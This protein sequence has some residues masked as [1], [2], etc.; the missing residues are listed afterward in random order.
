MNVT[1]IIG[2]GF[3]LA[4]GLKTRYCH[5][6]DEYC[7]TPSNNNTIENF[8]KELLNEKYDKW[9]DFEMAL[10]QF[11][12]DLNDFGK[13]KECVIDFTI[14]LNEYLSKEEK[15]I[16]ID[17]NKERLGKLMTS[18]VYEF[19]KYCLKPSSKYLEGMINK[20]NEQTIFNFITFNYTDT[21]E[22]CLA[23][24][25]QRRKPRGYNYVLNTPVHIHGKLNNGIILGLDDEKWYKDI[26][27]DDK[28]KIKNL[29][30]KLYINSCYFDITEKTIQTIQSS[31]IIVI[32][33]W[34]MGDSDSYWVN[35]IKNQFVSNS[36]LQIVFSPYYFDTLNRNI[37]SQR[38]DRKDFWKD[39]IADKFDIDE[40][41]KYR[42]NIITEDNYMK[43]KFLSE[44]IKMLKNKEGIL[45]TA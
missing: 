29:L 34:S 26:P 23:T 45:V 39:I 14:F 38:I 8:K 11:A 32:L 27:C 30:D 25:G 40:K 37:P 10:P 7:V 43:L 42:I 20:Q 16:N 24:M 41:H 17:V 31:N 6:Y 36:R 19:N 28:R 5:I 35:C 21:L 13:F 1:F 4:C 2:N 3:D 18:Y 12:K 33:G 15:R 44:D 22:K 9:S